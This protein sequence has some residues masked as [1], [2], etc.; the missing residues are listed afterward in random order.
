V[1]GG[2]GN[3]YRGMIVD[4][5]G[6]I[7]VVAPNGIN[8][9]A[10][11]EHSIVKVP[12]VVAVTPVAS[13]PVMLEFGTKRIFPNIQGIDI[14]KSEKVVP[15]R[16]YIVAGSLDDLDDDTVILSAVLARTIGAGLGSKVVVVTPLALEKSKTDEAVLPTELTVTGIFEFGHQQLD[17][18]ILITTLRR[19][20][21]L[22]GLGDSVREFDVKLAPGVDVIEAAQRI[23]AA[24]PAG[25][26]ATARTWME[27]SEA[28]LFALQMEKT[29]VILITSFVVLIATFLVTALLLITVVRKTRE[30]GLLGALGG[31][32]RQTAACFCLQGFLVGLC[33][34]LVG[35]GAGFLTLENIDGIFHFLGRV[36]GSWDNLVAIYQ[37]SQVPAH[38]TF[39]E[40]L[41]ISTYTISMATIAGL[42]SAWRAAK[43]T[44]VEAMRTE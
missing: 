17:S 41:G 9:L 5:Q 30:I 11:F 7:Q 20:Q 3:K 38:I 4:T 27:A 10:E 23:N 28:F 1:M 31:L 34:T 21:D 35:L 25:S 32:P 36:T 6:E 44:P 39:G 37:F 13:G 14:E 8:R 24:L 15:L 29:M 42:I 19:M 2:F 33:G 43:L 40:V 16:K 22:Y 12:G 18:S 26:G